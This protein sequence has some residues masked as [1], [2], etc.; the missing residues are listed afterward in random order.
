MDVMLGDG[1]VGRRRDYS[2]F[3]D[4]DV[5]GEVDE[6]GRGLWMSSATWASEMD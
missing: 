3:C 2:S 1:D 4:E 5:T 6:E